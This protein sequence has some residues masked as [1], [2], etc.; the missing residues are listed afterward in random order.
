MRSDLVYG[1]LDADFIL[2]GIT[3][4]WGA[5]TRAVEAHLTRSYRERF[6]GLMFDFS[7]RIERVYTAVFL[8]D[9]IVAGLKNEHNAMLFVHHPIREYYD[10]NRDC[11]AETVS[12]ESVRLLSGN[13]IAVYNLHIPLDHFSPC[14]TNTTLAR[15]L[16]LTV[17]EKCAPYRGAYTGVV[18]GTPFLTLGELSNRIETVLGHEAGVYA[19]GDADIGSKP[20]AIVAGCGH[21][22]EVIDE[23]IASGIGTLVTG[24]SLR[25]ERSEALHRY[26]EL[27][28]IN[29]IGGTHYSTEKFALMKMCEYFSG[30]GLPAEFIEQ[31]PCLLDL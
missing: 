5:E 8:C 28:R 23:L 20:V 19:Y 21:E 13:S 10:R 26:D 29:V 22:R 14:G 17:L 1:K 30:M 11:I 25:C 2:D 15:A 31:N 4:D 24:V 16:G 18:C 7:P 27:N 6:M 12:E 9:E 3:D